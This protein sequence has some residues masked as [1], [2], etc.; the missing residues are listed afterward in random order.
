MKKILL[1][2]IVASGLFAGF[3]DEN[4]KPNH[5]MS[6]KQAY[7]SKD[8]THVSLKGHIIKSLGDEKYTFSDGKNQ[9]IIEIDDKDW[10]GLNVTKH[11]LVEIQGEVDKDMFEHTKID[12]NI[13]KKIK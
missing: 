6:V 12:V 5:V 1:S 3:I 2:C 10:R 7:N 9:I 4:P 13:I 8:D 11:D